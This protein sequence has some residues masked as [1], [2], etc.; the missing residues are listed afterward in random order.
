MR[1]T[2]DGS[3]VESRYD[4]ILAGLTPE[5]RTAS[6]AWYRD[7]ERFAQSLT[8]IRPDWTVEIAASV[9]SALSPRERWESNKAKA[10]TF[11]QGG[12]IRGLGMNLRRAHAATREGF[13]A[14]RGPKTA[15]FARA[16]AGDPDAVVIDTWMLKPLDKRSVTPAQYGIIASAVVRCA[17]RVNLTP[18]ETQAAIWIIA[19]GAAE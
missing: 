6:V 4:S 12:T 19:R 8:V 3:V 10:L 9:M 11:A 14:L 16:I 7:A 17:A 13:A 2:I 5:V 1:S 15:A 18:R